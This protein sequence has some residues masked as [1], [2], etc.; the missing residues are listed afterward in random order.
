[1]LVRVSV[2]LRGV[3][4]PRSKGRN[5]IPLLAGPHFPSSYQFIIH[6]INLHSTP[7]C[8]SSFVGLLT[9]TSIVNRLQTSYY[10][11]IANFV[12]EFRIVPHSEYALST[13][14][15]HIIFVVFF[16]DFLLLPTKN[17]SINKWPI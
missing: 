14:T 11:M 3:N 2:I 6:L 9:D 15:S 16:M 12:E 1:M 13:F 7:C 10:I 4:F 8:V 5:S 17:T